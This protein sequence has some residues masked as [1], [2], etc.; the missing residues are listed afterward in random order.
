[1]DCNYCGER[2]ARACRK[3]RSQNKGAETTN[4]WTMAKFKKERHV[5][6]VQYGQSQGTDSPEEEVSTAINTVRML[7]IDD[8]S[9][10]FWVR[11]EIE[12]H[13]IKMQMDAVS[14]AVDKRFLQH[15]Q[16]K[17]L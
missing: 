1:M 5:R 11:P 12:G 16:H 15:L 4:N 8:T 10:S 9:D 14:Y 6:S 7:Q 2:E 3:Q 17:I 13:P